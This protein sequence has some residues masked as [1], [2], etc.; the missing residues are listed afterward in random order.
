MAVLT[1]GVTPE[2]KHNLPNQMSGSRFPATYAGT[3]VPGLGRLHGHGLV[4]P[5]DGDT[6][7][8][9]SATFHHT[10]GSGV[11]DL[12]YI[13]NGSLTSCTFVS[14]T[15]VAG[16]DFGATGLQ[17]D[18][19]TESTTNAGTSFT[20]QVIFPGGDQ[21]LMI[22][23]ADANTT[24]LEANSSKVHLIPN[25]SADRIYTLPPNAAGLYYEFWSTLVAADGHDVQ[26]VAD[27]AADFYKGTLRW[28]DTNGT[29]QYV[30][31][32]PNGTND[33]TLN[34]ILPIGFHIKMY[35]DGTNWF[36][37]GTVEAD[38]TPTWT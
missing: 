27:N 18:T 29:T 38:A 10:D 5:T 36:I 13:N 22:S 31:L 20:D 37:T 14:I 26:I 23:L 15:S 21:T 25:V 17:A 32:S 7:W 4:I 1:T 3:F 6:G 24:I 30:L 33:H 9:K 11:D 2:V 12:M 16:A 35:C 34:I 19:I 28:L 8:A